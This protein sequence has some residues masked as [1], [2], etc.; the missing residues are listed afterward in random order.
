V[1]FD[2]LLK[3]Y[4]LAAVLAL[5]AVAA[6]LQ[7][8]GAMQ[9]V[10]AMLIP[11]PSA[12]AILPPAPSAGHGP[13]LPPKSANPILS[14]NP[15]DYSTGPLNAATLGDKLPVAE[16]AAPTDPL[17]APRCPDIKVSI[18]TESPDPLWSIAALQ[19]PGE[20]RPTIR[21]V[22]ESAGGSKVAF[23]GYNAYEG[24]P[25][26]W[27]VQGAT[28]CQALLFGPQPQPPAAPAAGAAAASAAAP[29]SGSGRGAPALPADM[30]A[31]IQRVSPTE[32]NV[33]RSVVDKILE[34]Q[35]DLMRS[36][37]VVPEQQDG[38]V[39]GVRLFGIRPDTLLGTLGLENGDRLETIN[40][41]AM[42][43]PEKA[44]E[45]YARLRTAEKLT[46]SVNRRGQ[47]VTIEFNIK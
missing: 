30:K 29:H 9:L 5:V 21:R 26:V 39:V 44:L 33:D 20:T 23:I 38:K 18:I 19:G 35:A 11:D 34:N 17:R 12:L 42:A 1:G 3:K 40:G 43:S 14:R 25:S 24:S 32:F 13:S 27:L 10:G 2:A 46:V 47:P 4:F 36:A 16:A 37:R 7:A 28:L 31:K 22:G 6:F 45:A 15:F 41:F 8:R